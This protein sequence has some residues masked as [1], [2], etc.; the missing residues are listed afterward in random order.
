[1]L[2]ASTIFYFSLAFQKLIRTVVNRKYTTD[3]SPFNFIQAVGLRD[4]FMTAKRAKLK[5]G[6]F[7]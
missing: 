1:M 4:R 5:E 7:P 3:L 6:A 2:Q